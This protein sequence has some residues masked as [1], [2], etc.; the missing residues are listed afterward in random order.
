MNHGDAKDRELLQATYGAVFF[1]VPNN[2]KDLHLLRSMVQG[3]PNEAF[4]LSLGKIQ[5]F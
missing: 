4:V 3:Q 1:G 5:S 2:G